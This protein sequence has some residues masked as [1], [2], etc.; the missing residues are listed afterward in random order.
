[1]QS[2]PEPAAGTAEDDEFE[3]EPLAEDEE[4]AEAG[5]GAVGDEQPQEE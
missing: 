5:E 2:G 3:D 4:D 1:M